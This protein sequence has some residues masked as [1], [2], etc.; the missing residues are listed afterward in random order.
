MFEIKKDF[1]R[2][3]VSTK[4]SKTN[5]SIIFY[6][7]YSNGGTHDRLWYRGAFY[8]TRYDIYS[9]TSNTFIEST[10]YFDK[11]DLF[12]FEN[13]KFSDSPGSSEKVIIDSITFPQVVCSHMLSILDDGRI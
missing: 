1:P 6:P 12:F 9:S 11:L 4:L 10:L 7:N 8:S 3:T 2:I 5:Y 13:Q